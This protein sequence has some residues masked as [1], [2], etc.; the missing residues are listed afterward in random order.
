MQG[1]GAPPTGG[2]SVPSNPYDQQ[3]APPTGPPPPQPGGFPPQ[4]NT[5]MWCVHIQK[6]TPET[7]QN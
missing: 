6:E 4:V 3:Q 5:C 2:A 1:A 7:W